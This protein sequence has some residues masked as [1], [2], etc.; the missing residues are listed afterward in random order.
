[1]F[2]TIQADISV[3]GAGGVDAEGAWADA[4]RILWQLDGDGF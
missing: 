4:G 2:K 1:M 3:A